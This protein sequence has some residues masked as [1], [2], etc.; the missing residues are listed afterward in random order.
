[1]N[2]GLLNNKQLNKEKVRRMKEIKKYF[3]SFLKEVKESVSKLNKSEHETSRKESAT[4]Q[5][6]NPDSL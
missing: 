6:T 2:S 1:M 5:T 3:D 4:D